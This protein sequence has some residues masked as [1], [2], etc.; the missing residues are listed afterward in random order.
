MKIPKRNLLARK[1]NNGKVLVI[2]GNEVFHGAPILTALGVEKSGVD[3]IFPFVPPKHEIMTKITSEN[4]IVHTFQKNIFTP[5]DAQNALNLCQNAD[6]VVVGNGLGKEKETECAILDFLTFVKIPVIID[7]DAIISGILYVPNK[8]NWI[9]TPH[10]GEFQRLFKEKGTKTNVQKQAK[11]HQFT[12]LKKGKED[13]I[14]D[15]KQ[16]FL[17]TTGCPEMSIGGTGDALA[18]ITAGFL[19]QGLSPF[20]AAQSATYFWGKCGEE[21][22]K[23]KF[24]FTTREML[25]RFP[26]VVKNEEKVFP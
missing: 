9:L 18:G 8:K 25:E 11:I 4:F 17:N 5:K 6:V 10:E 16:N 2:G 14:T 24:S 22:Q 12:I 21:L 26:Y 1:G 7:A 19:S 23:E 3:L 13:I 15:K 20:E